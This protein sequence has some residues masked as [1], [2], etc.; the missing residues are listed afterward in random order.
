ML[1]WNRCTDRGKRVY[2]HYPA[3]ITGK[4]PDCRRYCSIR[5]KAVGHSNFPHLRYIPP[6]GM[7]AERWQVSW[8]ADQNRLAL[9]SHLHLETVVHVIRERTS[10]YRLQLR[11]QPRL[12]I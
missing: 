2:L 7:V 1:F 12:G 6:D 4:A 11:E 10:G 8:L 3:Q 9:P 5:G